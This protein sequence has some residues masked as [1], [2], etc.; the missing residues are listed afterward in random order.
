[1]E[2][3]LALLYIGVDMT[4]YYTTD[5]LAGDARALGRSVCATFGKDERRC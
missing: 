4:P 3:F 1:M 5:T 2:F